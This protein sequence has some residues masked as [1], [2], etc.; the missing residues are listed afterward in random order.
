MIMSKFFLD[1]NTDLDFFDELKKIMPADATEADILKA[2]RTTTSCYL[3]WLSRRNDKGK[4][5]AIELLEQFVA[6]LY[7]VCSGLIK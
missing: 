5:K 1:S 4:D 3:I 7:Y 2:L 6:E